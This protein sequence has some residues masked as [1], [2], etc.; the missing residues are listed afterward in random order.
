MQAAK[1]FTLGTF[2]YPAYDIVPHPEYA[3]VGLVQLPPV[4]VIVVTV[5]CEV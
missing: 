5:G 4:K 2:P 1:H 3:C